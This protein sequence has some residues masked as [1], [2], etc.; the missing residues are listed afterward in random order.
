MALKMLPF[1]VPSSVLSSEKDLIVFNIAP[2]VLI[3]SIEIREF[4]DGEGAV[5]YHVYDRVDVHGSTIP[6]WSILEE[7]VWVSQWRRRGSLT[8]SEPRLAMPAW[9]SLAVVVC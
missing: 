4:S 1:S 8:S 9:N 7:N 5:K 2:L 3:V 6:R